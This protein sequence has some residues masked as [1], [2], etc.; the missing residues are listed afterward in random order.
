M[1][2]VYRT[3][4]S[5]SRVGTTESRRSFLFRSGAAGSGILLAGYGAPSNAAD[6]A[7]DLVTATED[8]MREHGVLRRVLILYTEVA[9]KL[10]RD[11]TAVDPGPI[12]SATA[13]L[14]EFGEDYHERT[15]EE[16]HVFPEVRRAGGA[17][18]KLVDTLEA[19]HRR[20]REITDY[21]LGVVRRGT[22]NSSDGV[23]MAGTLEGFVRMYRSHAAFEDTLVFPAWK[24]ALRPG[25]LDELAEQFEDIE[26]ERFGEDG[27]GAALERIASAERAL[28]LDDL[29][30]FTAAP[31]AAA[32]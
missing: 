19:Q 28:G 6:E 22:I 25:R 4:S 26:H 8:L 16:Q 3:K 31:P 11:A 14:R 27:F 7:A 5:F 13:L 30:K 20:G 15:L 17:A 18:G 1:H 32:H 9:E 10:R 24:M 21:V 23:A 12:L 2:I 29:A